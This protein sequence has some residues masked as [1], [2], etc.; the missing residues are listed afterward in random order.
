VTND[1]APTFDWVHPSWRDVVIDFLMSHQNDRQ[2]FLRRCD[3]AG[4]E[5][6]LSVS[7]GATGER[8]QPLMQ[9]AEDWHVLRRRMLEL[10][11][12]LSQNRHR[13][14]LQALQ[15]SVT[16]SQ[17]DL[18]AS[19]RQTAAELCTAVVVEW[20]EREERLAPRSL[21]A[22][23]QLSI[24][25]PRL[26]PGPQLKSTIASWIDEIESG[27]SWS[28]EPLDG[29]ATVAANEPRALRHAGWAER[30][31]ACVSAV[32]AAAHEA[33]ADA[34]SIHADI[35]SAD[36]P[37]IDDADT[38][39]YHASRWQERLTNLER[40]IGVSDETRLLRAQLSDVESTLRAWVERETEAA[41][42]RAEELAHEMQEE[43]EEEE[44]DPGDDFD[45][46]E[47]LSDL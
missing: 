32:L 4:L 46:Q 30:R 19:I 37:S 27:G 35:E 44:D 3:V 25:V 13:A 42:E 21:D 24:L 40:L 34:E 36:E 8:E 22:F 31:D 14:L 43:E 5:L 9:T 6:A 33:V 23:Y 20:D 15:V 38:E 17:G 2:R 10:V 18:Q 1:A 12:H 11:P 41:A 29:L 39:A 28:Y 16:T 45:I 26:P 47:V 7:G